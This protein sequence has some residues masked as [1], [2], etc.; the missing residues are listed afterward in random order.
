[1]QGLSFYLGFGFTLLGIAYTLVVLYVKGSFF[2]GERRPYVRNGIALVVLGISLIGRAFSLHPI[3]VYLL[4]AVSAY[5]AILANI[6][7]RR[8]HRKS[9]PHRWPPV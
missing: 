3:A 6:E 2:G 4:W 9:V 1:M 5:L 7:I 8:D